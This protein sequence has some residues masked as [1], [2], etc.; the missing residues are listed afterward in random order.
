[1]GLRFDLKTIASVTLVFYLLPVSVLL[2]IF[3]NQAAILRFFDG[4]LFGTFSLVILI[5][6][7]G[8]GYYSHFGAPIDHLMFGLWQDGFKEVV[9]SMVVNPLVI[10]LSL[11]LIVLTLLFY[12]LFQSVRSSMKGV[13]YSRLTVILSFIILFLFML[14]FARGSFGSLPLSK[15]TN[16]GNAD[17]VLNALALNAFMDLYNA[18]RDN[19][20]D[21]LNF[22]SAQIL[23]SLKLTSFEELKR[24]AGYNDNYPLIQTTSKKST[25][26][27]NVVFILMEGWSSHIALG[28]SDNNNILG[29]FNKHK[30]EDF[31]TTKFVSNSYGTNPSIE[32]ILLNSPFGKVSTSKGRNISYST[33]NIMPFKNAGYYL[34]FISGGNRAWRN[35][36]NF[37]SKQGFDDFFDRSHIRDFTKVTSDNPWGAYEEDLF[38]FVKERLRQTKDEKSFSFVLTT[39][40]HPPVILP[41]GFKSPSYNYAQYNME[42]DDY[43]REMLDAYY[44]ASDELGNFLTW[45]KS[46]EFAENTIVVATG[47]HILKGFDN[48]NAKH[49]LFAKFSVPFY[50]YIPDQYQQLPKSDITGS[51]VDIFPTL[52]DLSL[53]EESYYAFGNSLLKKTPESSYAW[54]QG[55]IG[56]FPDGITSNNERYEWQEGSDLY[57]NTEPKEMSLFQRQ[58]IQQI[59]YQNAVARYLIFKDFEANK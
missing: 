18:Y 23:S 54:H 47:D 41:E 15:K 31:F 13:T 4:L 40:N 3:K 9:L 53:S 32:R 39:N 7:T 38:S 10:Y 28:Q 16:Q 55:S 5:C 37:Y 52:Y 6:L 43:L 44:Y 17:P 20:N 2:L 35:T 50:A 30:N 58:M 25:P 8:Y 24:H 22:S 46:S 19:Q 59:S 51:H 45:L 26:K 12:K 56:L 11:G 42:G 33:S 57:L 36:G 48:Y 34:Q 29:A 27:P 14:S 21:T 1:M 49:K